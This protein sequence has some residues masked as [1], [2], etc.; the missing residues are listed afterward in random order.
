M[1]DVD[2]NILQAAIQDPAEIIQGGSVHREILA[3]LVDG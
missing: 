2:G 3:E 1:R